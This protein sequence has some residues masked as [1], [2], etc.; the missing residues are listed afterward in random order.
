MNQPVDEAA[1][2]ALKEQLLSALDLFRRVGEERGLLSVLDEETRKEMM[3]VL[4]RVSRPD[5]NE[6]RKLL[7]AL[8]KRER[9]D[10]RNKD[11]ELLE[12]TGIRSLRRRADLHHARFRSATKHIDVAQ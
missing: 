8:R 9:A 3:I 7:R 5:R 2:K 11:E 6:V 12:A 1:D 10:E 4:G